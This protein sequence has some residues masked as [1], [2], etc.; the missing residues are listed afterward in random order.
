MLGI[1]IFVKTVVMKII[2]DVKDKNAEFFLELVK[3]LDFVE[4]V[5]LI[6]NPAKEKAVQD[7]LMAFEDIAKYEKGK[8]KLKSAKKLLNEL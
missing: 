8:K 3:K 4:V 2:L 6:N 1:R 7:V 5:K